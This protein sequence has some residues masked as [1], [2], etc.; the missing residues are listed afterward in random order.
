MTTRFLSRLDLP[1]LRGTSEESS[2]AAE[3]GWLVHFDAKFNAR[4]AKEVRRKIG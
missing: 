3:S 2:W 1:R 4:G